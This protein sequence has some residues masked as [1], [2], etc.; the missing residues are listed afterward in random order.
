MLLCHSCDR[1]VGSYGWI[2]VASVGN[3]NRVSH[4]T[5]ALTCVQDEVYE[6]GVSTLSDILTERRSFTKAE[7]LA[8]KMLEV[9]YKL[10]GSE[11][12]PVS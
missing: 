6:D 3:A 4:D 1:H 12:L 11:S 10:Y 8:R 9:K 7:M 5:I 2:T